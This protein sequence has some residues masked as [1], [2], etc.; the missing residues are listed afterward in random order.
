MATLDRNATSIIDQLQSATARQR[1]VIQQM[2]AEQAKL[3]A[4]LVEVRRERDA[5]RNEAA[6]FRRDLAEMHNRYDEVVT[7]YLDIKR[8]RLQLLCSRSTSESNDKYNG[9]A[10]NGT[11]TPDRAS[12]TLKRQRSGTKVIILSLAW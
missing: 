3:L 1:K 7:E 12:G 5:F 6:G 8:E 2:H 10:D 9:H 4:D 11:R